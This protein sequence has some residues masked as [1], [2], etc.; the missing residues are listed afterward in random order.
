MAAAAAPRIGWYDR[1]LAGLAPGYAIR[2]LRA[3]AALESYESAK[4]TRLRRRMRDS[5][6]P[7]AIIYDSAEKVR[8][9]ARDLERNY[10]LAR[11]ALKVLVR[12]VIGADGVQTEPMPKGRDGKTHKVFA[13]QITRLLREWSRAPEVTGQFDWAGAQRRLCNIWL[14]D[15]EGFA[16][17][18]EGNVPLLRHGTRVPLSLELLEADLVPMD[19]DD[20]AQN[21]RQ[22]VK[23]NAW[24]KPVSVFVYKQHPFD[25]GLLQWNGLDT[26]EVPASRILHLALRDRLHQTRGLSIFASV[27]NRL[28]DLKD[29]EDA[30][31]IAAR[32][33]ASMAA[34]IKRDPGGDSSTVVPT[35]SEDSGRATFMFEHGT[36]WDGARPGDDFHVI[37]TKRPNPNIGTF[38][39]DQTRR[40]S[41]GVDVGHSSTSRDYNGTYSAQRQELVEQWSAYRLLTREFAA[42]VVQPV[43]ERLIGMALAA[44]LLQLPADLDVETLFH[45][46]HRGPAMP[47]IDPAKEWGAIEIALRVRGTSLTKV[48]RERGEDPWE[49]FHQIADEQDEMKTLGITPTANSGAMRETAP[50]PAPGEDDAEND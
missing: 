33:N 5:R 9:Y 4:N 1:L 30:E 43:Y 40:I 31:R 3:R 8:N 36:I 34:L 45:A 48:L 13:D 23:R 16:Q 37:D 19:Y 7:D 26:K 35:S 38:M 22:G 41:A 17:I 50:V 11:G 46:D 25:T 44:G 2:R 24:G 39:K 14:R 6:S 10:D 29:Y 28:E 12:N 47:W 42:Q 18:L 15:G 49:M 21:I 20:P 27:I 32:I